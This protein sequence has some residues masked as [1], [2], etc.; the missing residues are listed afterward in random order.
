MCE[1]TYTHAR[2]MSRTALSVEE[3][4]LRD[5]FGVFGVSPKLNKG[6]CDG[7]QC[8]PSATPIVGGGRGLSPPLPL[9]TSSIHFSVLCTCYHFLC[10]CDT[11]KKLRTLG[12]YLGWEKEPGWPW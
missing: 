2:R 8:C 12:K 3:Q 7:L 4:H 5:V 10:V 11:M 6:Q 1:H 9:R